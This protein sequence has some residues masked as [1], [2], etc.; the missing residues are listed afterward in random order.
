MENKM[1]VICV[2]DEETVLQSLELELQNKLG[3]CIL[4][5][6]QSGEEA[7]EI[8]EE[9]RDKGYDIPLVICDYIM[10]NLK[11]DEVLKKIYESYPSTYKI[12]LTGQADLSGV[13]RAINEA[14]IYRYIAKPWEREDLWLTVTAAIE[15]YCQNQEI[16]KT[17]VAME[18]FVPRELMTLLGV[19]KLAHMK[20]GDCTKKEV[21]VL[22]SDIRSFTTISEDMSPQKT[23]DFLNSYFELMAPIIRQYNG[24]IN[25]FIGDGIMAIFPDKPEDAVDAAIMMLQVLQEHSHEL[26]KHSIEIGIGIHTGRVILGTL[27]DRDRMEATII[28]DTV[29]VA[30][31]MEEM[32]KYLGTPLLISANSYELIDERENYLVRYLGPL[33][34]R[35]KMMHLP[36]LEVYNADPPEIRERKQALKNDFQKAL[37]CFQEGNRAEARK[38][39]EEYQAANP[40]DGAIA[41]YLSKLSESS[42]KT[43]L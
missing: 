8:C 40:D 34:V 21:T 14:N 19:D 3:D 42:S 35:G 27:G 32:T 13:V 16:E 39:F 38:M 4:E 30:S 33:E 36:V 9:Y 15:H 22:F 6:A 10:P 18:K 11:G 41:F 12:M 17:Y 26:L 5:L 1:V 2:D 28:G 29:N 24:F 7:L 23:F 37:L 25:K 43:H 20:F 31:R